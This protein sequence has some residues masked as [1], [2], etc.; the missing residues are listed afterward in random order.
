M[1][2]P[3]NIG[4]VQIKSRNDGY[5]WV[6]VAS[7]RAYSGDGTS[8]N[9]TPP[10]PVGP[11]TIG[12]TGGTITTATATPAPSGDPAQTAEPAATEEPAATTDPEMNKY[13]TD[14]ENVSWAVKSINKLAELGIV[15]GT[16]EGIFSPELNVTRAEYITML[17]RGFGSEVQGVEVPFS[18]VDAAEWYY[19]PISKAYALEIA[20]GYS[21]D[22][23]VYFGINDNITRE[24]MMV[25]AYR[26]LLAF[27]IEVP[28]KKSYV[29]FSDQSSISDYAVEAVDKMYCAEIINGVGDNMLD[30]KGVADRA[31]SA[32][33]IYGLIDMEG[34]VNE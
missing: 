15:Q 33:V 12:Q 28:A 14:L 16:S 20:N 6:N 2:E 22:N 24:D 9:V 31:Q 17:M 19:E 10:A 7:I 26:T 1:E 3:Y 34:T 29:A 5:S 13:F 11:G 21:D 27:D 4:K 30:P 18:D 8:T 23:G 25:M 32:K